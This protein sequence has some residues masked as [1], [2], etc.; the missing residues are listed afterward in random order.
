MDA[1]DLLTKTALE[2]MYTL[3]K[4][5]D[6]DVVY[7]E[8]YFTAVADGSDVK[9]TAWQTS[10]LSEEPTLEPENLAEK[11]Q[12][13]LRRDYW[14][15]VWVKLTRRSLLIENEIF[16][17]NTKRGDDDIWSYGVVLY[18]K[19]LLRVPNAVY[20]MRQ[21]EDSITRKKKTPQQT[22]NF[23]LNP[24]ILGLKSIDKLLSKLEFFKENPLYRYAILEQFV[25]IMFNM[26]F[27]SAYKL[28]PFEVYEAIKQEFGDRLGEQDVLIP[29]LC[30]YV[31]T[32]QKVFF[33][34][35]QKFN[36]YAAQAQ[37]RIAELEAQ[38]KTK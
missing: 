10:N 35:Q 38:L 36:E 16:F 24:M 29:V 11:V 23:W 5:Y 3:A 9:L 2:E 26:I 12:R 19:K 20:I 18:A 22:I 30:A 6:A 17:P 32:Q 34:N 1:D 37:R 4:D 33:M 8:K 15:T 28:Q 14:V 27:E 25:T 31:N 13:I 21:S 7:C